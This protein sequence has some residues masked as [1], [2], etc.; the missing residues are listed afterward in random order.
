MLQCGLCSPGGAPDRSHPREV[1]VQL[2][3]FPLLLHFLLLYLC[4]GAGECTAVMFM[5]VTTHI[6]HTWHTKD[7][8][9]GR[10]HATHGHAAFI[11]SS[12]SSQCVQSGTEMN[13]GQHTKGLKLRRIHKRTKIT[14]TKGLK[15][16]RRMCKLRLI[17]HIYIHSHSFHECIRA[18][19]LMETKRL[20]PSSTLIARMQHYSKGYMAVC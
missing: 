1:S 17:L 18:N 16:R 10:P 15:L 5:P 12:V 11:S 20:T 13:G 14:S 2:L 19:T 8:S 6:Q 7:T 4:A 9:S 3:L